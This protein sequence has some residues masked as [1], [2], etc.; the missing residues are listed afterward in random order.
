MNNIVI[1]G[2][3]AS[4]KTA[5]AAEV[6]KLINGEIIS[7]DSRQVYKYLD[8]GTNKSGE[9]NAGKKARYFKG[10][11]QYL[12]DLIEPNESFSAG[13]FAKLA[14]EK[15]NQLKRCGKTPIIVGGTG[16]YIKA[17][18]DGLAPL[19]GKDYKIRQ[20]LESDLKTRG[21]EYLYEKLKKVD[22][23]SAEK[24]A[25][26]PQRLIR[27]LEIFDLTGMP[28]TRLH[29]KTIPSGENFLQFGL[30]WPREVLYRNIDQ[31]TEEMIKTGIIEETKTVLEKGF[32]ASSEAFR[33]IGYKYVLEY[34]SGEINKKE[35]EELISRDT[36]RYAKRQITW[37]KRDKRISWIELKETAFNATK[38]AEDIL[39]KIDNLV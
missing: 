29:K 8:V 32:V 26:N 28:I 20:K 14:K 38:I 27:A 10:I 5:V 11:P 37:F 30:S 35:S 13:D 39:K 1:T 33:S 18:I 6:A 2:P 15:I 16:L 34:L 12:T 4:G 3:T 21:I 22:P 17:L 19:P 9:W 31:R 23:E 24:N 7:A 36:R 25:K